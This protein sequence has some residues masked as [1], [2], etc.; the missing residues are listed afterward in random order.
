MDSLRNAQRFVL[1]ELS[2]AG[3]TEEHVQSTDF[4]LSQEDFISFFDALSSRLHKSLSPSSIHA[5]ALRRLKPRASSP[6]YASLYPLFRVFLFANRIERV[7]EAVLACEESQAASDD[8][9]THFSGARNAA[10]AFNHSERAVHGSHSASITLSETLCSLHH[11]YCHTSDYAAPYTSVVAPSGV[12]KSFSVRSLAL[13]GLHHVFYASL[14]SKTVHAFPT[15][16]PLADMLEGWMLAANARPTEESRKAMPVDRFKNL[17]Y[18]VILDVQ[19]CVDIQLSPAAYFSLQI[20]ENS[21]YARDFIS[22]LDGLETNKTFSH[23]RSQFFDD[24]RSTLRAFAKESSLSGPQHNLII[25]CFDEARALLSKDNGDL[26]FRSF[27]QALYDTWEDIPPEYGLFA[28]LMDTTSRIHNFLPT[29]ERDHSLKWRH[30]V[31]HCA[32]NLFP[33]IY[34]LNTFDIWYDP[35]FTGLDTHQSITSIRRL[36]SLGRPCGVLTLK[37]T[38]KSMRS[39]LWRFRKSRRMEAIYPCSLTAS[40]SGS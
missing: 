34:A 11:R 10:S 37:R 8:F 33:P 17:I 20:S 30:D 23:L 36:F 40:I 5:A 24:R 13:N 2:L 29:H 39:S 18:A 1:D 3:I 21:A 12:G 31:E 15:R 25:L 19:A 38:L 6:N 4:N 16:S 7:L 14:A 35:D 26:L 22:F 32:S 28:I 27:R 9:I